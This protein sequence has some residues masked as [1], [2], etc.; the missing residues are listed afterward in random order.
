[1]EGG[2]EMLYSFL[3]FEAGRCFKICLVLLAGFIMILGSNSREQTI[4]YLLDTMTPSL[5]ES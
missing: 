4:W 5:T 1:M 3:S 2:G